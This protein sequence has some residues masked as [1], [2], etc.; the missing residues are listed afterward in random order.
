MMPT[1][2]PPM[3]IS[4]PPPTISTSRR[5]MTA[6]MMMMPGIMVENPFEAPRRDFNVGAA[7]IPPAGNSHKWRDLWRNRRRLD[8]FADEGIDGEFEVGDRFR[9]DELLA[10]INHLRPTLAI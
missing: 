3:L 1:C 6:P 5:R 8:A 7:K 9:E 10:V 4:I 2:W